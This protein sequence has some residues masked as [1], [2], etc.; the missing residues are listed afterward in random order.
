[1]RG[2]SI[3][4]GAV[5]ML[6]LGGC[7][8]LPVYHAPAGAKTVPV[9]IA[10]RGAKSVCIGYLRYALEPDANGNVYLVAGDR[11]TLRSSYSWADGNMNWSCH[12]ATSFVPDA[13]RAYTMV[14]EVEPENHSCTFRVY[15]QTTA[16]RIGLDF[17]SSTRPPQASCGP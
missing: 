11:V 2:A 10:T 7:N 16:N 17:E 1:M 6:A 15:R 5:A 9:N 12:P 14:F 4:A 8:T 3:V 13:D